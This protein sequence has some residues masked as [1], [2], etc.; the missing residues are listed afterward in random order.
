MLSDRWFCLL[1]LFSSRL[2]I[3]SG[4]WTR[5]QNCFIGSLRFQIS[6]RSISLDLNS[7]DRKE[8]QLSHSLLSFSNVDDGFSRTATDAGRSKQLSLGFAGRVDALFQTASV[9]NPYLLRLK[10]FLCQALNPNVNDE[11]NN[12]KKSNSSKTKLRRFPVARLRSS[13]DNNEN[14]FNPISKVRP[15]DS[16]LSL[17]K[18]SRSA[19]SCL[20]TPVRI[21]KRRFAW[22]KKKRATA[23]RR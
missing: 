5:R 7:T 4:C 15:V 2:L 13:L 22:K 9:A 23:V 8:D 19:C 11:N 18:T 1:V 3:H 21:V 12:L 10:C 20:C 6:S 14:S 16:L 17:S